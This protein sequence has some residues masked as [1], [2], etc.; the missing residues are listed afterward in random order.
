MHTSKDV[1]VVVVAVGSGQHAR[2][3]RKAETVV[4][5][6]TAAGSSTQAALPSRQR[7]RASLP[8]GHSNSSCA[9]RS[10]LRPALAV[11]DTG[12]HR[13]QP[14]ALPMKG[15]T[16]PAPSCS[17]SLPP[18]PFPPSLCTCPADMPPTMD[19]MQHPPTHQH[20]ARQPCR[21]S[22]VPFHPQQD[23]HDHAGASSPSLQCGP[24]PQYNPRLR[25]GTHDHA[26]VPTARP[27][28]ATSPPPTHTHTPSSPPSPHT[29][30]RLHAVPAP[31]PAARRA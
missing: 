3:R 31:S 18:P 8:C 11:Q 15:A 19:P 9:Q 6:S 5:D 10:T 16:H 30:A 20:A 28:P 23:T 22:P 2:G 13:P 12:P 21:P 7:A 27:P 24:C 26:E 25:Q 14:P 17:C 29:D 1:V 4:R